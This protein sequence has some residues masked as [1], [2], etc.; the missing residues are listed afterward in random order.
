MRLKTIPPATLITLCVLSTLSLTGHEMYAKAQVQTWTVDDDG[1]AD[2]SKI[3]EAVNNAS[4]G[5]IIYVHAGIYNESVEINKSLSLIGEDRDL[6]TIQ[7]ED[8]DFVIY[9]TANNVTVQGFTINKTISRPYD[10][11]ISIVAGDNTIHHNKIVGVYWGIILYSFSKNLI[12]DNIIASSNETGLNLVFSTNNWVVGNTISNNQAG[13]S[14]TSSRN[15]WFVGNTISNNRDGITL[16]TFSSFNI[17]YRNNFL[18]AVKMEIGLVNTWNYSGEGNYWSNYEGT[19]LGGD[20][21][22]D[23]PYTPDAGI[24]DGSPLMGMFSSFDLVL[25]RKT[26]GVTLISN[27]TVADFRVEEGTET[28]NRIIRFNV[29]GAYG[30][31]GFSRIG[32]PTE[33]M[34][35][36]LVLVG[37]EETKPE[38]LG[39]S[40]NTFVYLYLTYSHINQT[41]V[42]ISSKTLNLYDEL[43]GSFSRL[44]DDLNSLTANYSRL[45]EEYDDL[46]ANYTQLQ[47]SYAELDS[48]YNDHMS[49]YQLSLNNFRSL[50]YIFA[51]AAGIF[52][53]A[54]IYLSK[55]LHMSTGK[56][57]QNKE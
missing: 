52:L 50:T 43:R 47:Q 18:D 30:T 4:S 55:R 11:G 37:G 9:I 27:S 14:L 33:L 17:F 21:I 8:S 57:V 3:Q 29:A 31:V 32:I 1:S 16:S 54:T 7:G 38:P 48:S 56:I 19:D 28:G 13:I 40:N 42:V 46:M 2:F 36:S 49:D 12:S 26:Y 22:G 51:S 20:G 6:T 10:S 45:L 41:I 35:Y 24:R 34:N 23:Q 15:N 25:A 44:Q 5:D 53:V 39:I